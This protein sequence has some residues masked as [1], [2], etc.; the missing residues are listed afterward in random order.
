MCE[1]GSMAQRDCVLIMDA[2]RRLRN[3]LWNLEEEDAEITHHLFPQIRAALMDHIIF[4]ERL[5]FPGLARPE[6]DAHAQEHAALTSV[7]WALE[8][9]LA[10]KAV[11]RCRSLLDVLSSLIRQHHKAGL[12]PRTENPEVTKN[13][14]YVLRL[15]RR[16]QQLTLERP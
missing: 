11:E 10:Q 15:L 6:R 4:E 3:V 2:V 16:S 5:V 7:L 13:E 12:E 14:Y 1:C 9:A 8:Q